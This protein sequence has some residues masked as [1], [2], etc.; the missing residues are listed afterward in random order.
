MT[1][2]VPNSYYR[3][4]ETIEELHRK[5]EEAKSETIQPDALLLAYFSIYE[6]VQYGNDTARIQAKDLEDNAIAQNRVI[7]EASEVHFETFGN[8]IN[9]A[10]ASAMKTIQFRNAVYGLT[11]G[12]ISKTDEA[13][14]IQKK[15]SSLIT[16]TLLERVNTT[17]QSRQALASLFTDKLTVMRQVANVGSSNEN[18]DLDNVSQGI[19]VAGALMHM[20][21]NVS[22]QI[23]R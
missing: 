11:G 1:N 10:R 21:V 18:A 13:K 12:A 22:Q 3:E 8:L 6:A 15:E 7:A 19:S 4:E 16:P 23:D 2:I 9:Q 5:Q 17:N 20:V 14:I